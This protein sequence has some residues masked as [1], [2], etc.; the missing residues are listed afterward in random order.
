M[1]RPT[2]WHDGKRV[3]IENI[4]NDSRVRGEK[5]GAQDAS[6][7][8]LVVS[9]DDASHRGVFQAQRVQSR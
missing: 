2:G 8:S 4:A 9:V 1:I 5:V 3:T 7:L 6:C